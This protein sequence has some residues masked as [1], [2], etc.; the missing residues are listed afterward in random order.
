MPF[1]RTSESG[2]AKLEM[3]SVKVYRIIAPASFAASWKV[4]CPA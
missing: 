3:R 2:I 4:N 1:G